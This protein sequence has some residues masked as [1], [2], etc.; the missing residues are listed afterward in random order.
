MSP[1]LWERTVQAAS[2]SQRPSTEKDIQP[3]KLLTEGELWL[4]F[5]MQLSQLLLIFHKAVIHVNKMSA[6]LYHPRLTTSLSKSG[7]QAIC[8]VKLHYCINV[9]T[10]I[11]LTHF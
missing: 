11:F 3:Q 9:P 10:F 4:A 5:L 2:S 8:W 7:E 6:H 1:R